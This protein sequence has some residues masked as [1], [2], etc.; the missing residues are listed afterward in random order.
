M[1]FTFKIAPV[2]F[3][4]VSIHVS[5][6]NGSIDNRGGGGNRRNSYLNRNKNIR[7]NIKHEILIGKKSFEKQGG[8]TKKFEISLPLDL[9]HFLKGLQIDP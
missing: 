4:C 5:K 9:I 8:I 6:F 7:R 2:N 1:F 3:N